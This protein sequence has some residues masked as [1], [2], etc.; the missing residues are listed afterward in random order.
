MHQSERSTLEWMANGIDAVDQRNG[1]EAGRTVECSTCAGEDLSCRCGEERS[2]EGRSKEHQSSGTAGRGARRS[3][4][5]GRG[6]LNRH[7]E[8]GPTFARVA[9]GGK[10]G[11]TI[12]S[13]RGTSEKFHFLFAKKRPTESLCM[14]T[15]PSAVRGDRD[16]RI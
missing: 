7:G 11:M 1:E 4:T 12:R 3:V 8:R 2:G 14:R 16:E 9:E 13:I 10:R 6:Q 5:T 15:H